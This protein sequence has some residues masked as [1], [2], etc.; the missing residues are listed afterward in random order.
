MRPLDY[1]AERHL[2]D[3][4]QTAATLRG[5]RG[6]R[7]IDRDVDAVV[8]GAGPAGLVTGHV[9]ADAG[10]SVLVLEAGQFWQFSE[11]ERD[12]TWANEHLYQEQGTRV[13]KGNTAIPVASGRGVGGGTL[14][15]S[16]IS[17]R[18]PDR[19]L[20][21]WYERFGADI[22]APEHRERVFEQVEEAIGVA[23]TDPSIAGR[24]AEVARRGFDAL[25][26]EHGY[27][28]RSTPGCAGCGACQTGCPTGGKASADLNWLPE[29]LR[30]G[31]ELYADTRVEHIDVDDGRAVGVRGVARDP[32]TDEPVA[33]VRVRADRVILAC[34]AIYT[35]MMLQ[36]QGLA[37]SSGHVGANLHIHP[38]ISVIARMPED[39]E[40]W[41]GATQGYYAHHPSDP[42]LLAE[43]FSGPPEMF[44]TPA[45]EVGRAGMEF[46]RDLPRIA[47]CGALI[48]DVTSGYVEPDGWSADVTYFVDDRDADRL[49]KGFQ[50]LT[51]MFFEA[52]ADDVQ[53]LLRGAE[54]EEDRQRAENVVERAAAPGDFTLYASHPHG[55]CRMSADP[56]RGVVDPDDGE[57]HDVENLHVTDASVF[58]TALGVNPQV[59]IMGTALQLARR[60]AETG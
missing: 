7:R 26:V 39:V 31:G 16:G 38:A 44:Y 49:R 51:E 19:I 50:F 1:T 22:W 24:N 12:Q 9:L 14:V 53:P 43:T 47:G 46:L 57:T 27:M 11:F 59:T 45:A 58:P 13:A 32:A 60:I 10:L 36:K 17:F 25:G 4:L 15:N 42:N 2:G 56:D 5:E 33:D 40:I 41:R 34:G 35:P 3:R 8:A 29:M 21:D 6:L 20:D 54:F 55:T 23:P 48:R 37:D 52:G 18:A 30:N 28:P